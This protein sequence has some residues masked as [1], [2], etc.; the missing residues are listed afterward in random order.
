MHGPAR[1]GAHLDED[2]AQLAARRDE[3]VGPLETHAADAALLERR[4]RGDPH[5][6]AERGEIRR[7]VGVLPGH[8]KTH[9]AARRRDPGTAATAAPAGLVFGQHDG[10]RI[11][12]GRQR[13]QQSRI[14][15]LELPLHQQRLDA[16]PQP[17]RQRRQD[18]I[19]V[20]R[21]DTGGEL[22]ALVA[23]RL[24]RH[25]ELA[26]LL[27]GLPHRGAGHRQLRGQRLAGAE[28]AVVQALEHPLRQR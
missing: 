19:R 15:R 22:V 8:R 18:A 9:G 25:T 16:R 6:E 2:A 12:G 20:Q 26:Q 17:L 7:Q 24:E 14:R 11:R 1:L 28:L 21:G 23:L 10:R 3:V 13:L 4:D 5:D 27:D